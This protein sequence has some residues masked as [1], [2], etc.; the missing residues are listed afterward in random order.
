MERIG[1]FL[2]II[3]VLFIILEI[4]SCSAPFDEDHV[5]LQIRSVLELTTVSYTY[6]SIL[7]FEDVQKFLGLLPLSTQNLL[8]SVKTKVQA[9]IPLSGGFSI[10]Q[11]QGT[12][13][14]MVPE[15]TILLADADENSLFQYRVSEIGRKINWV[16]VGE[17]IAQNK[18]I[19]VEDARKAGILQ[20]AKE[21]TRMHIK[22]LMR[23]LD[24]PNYSIEFIPAI[25]PSNEESS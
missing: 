13:L 18:K 8:F 10:Q 2:R 5:S 6:K 11:N 14:F 19:L 23:S 7:Y 24:I 1:K 17:Q 3:F 20:K 25:I 4:T 21:N 9:G 16:D 15:P 12:I 22:E